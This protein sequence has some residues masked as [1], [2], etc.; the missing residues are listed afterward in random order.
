MA[1]KLENLEELLVHELKD[2]YSAET[3]LV[4]ALSR[5]V[6]AATDDTLRHG[7]QSHLKETQGHVQRLERALKALGESPRGKTCKAMQGL[8][9][10]GKETIAEKAEPEVRDAALIVAAQ[11]IEHYEIA[12]Y[13]SSRAFAELLGHDDVVELLDQTLAEEKAADVKLTEAALAINVAAEATG[14]ER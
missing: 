7:F 3:Q 2:L 13:G 8:I 9:A 5:M 1:S 12:G 14:E 10:E 11:K 4:K 6:K